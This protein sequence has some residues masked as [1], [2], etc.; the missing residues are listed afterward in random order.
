M[1]GLTLCRWELPLRARWGEQERDWH[2]ILLEH[3]P[4]AHPDSVM[5]STELVADVLAPEASDAVVT[6]LWRRIP[7]CLRETLKE[8]QEASVRFALRR[9]DHILLADE[10]NGP[11]IELGTVCRPHARWLAQS[12]PASP[13]PCRAVG[14]GKSLQ[15]RAPANQ[16]RIAA[17][18]MPHHP[19][20]S[21]THSRI[22]ARGLCMLLAP[23]AVRWWWQALAIAAAYSKPSAADEYFWPV[24][25]VC[26]TSMRDVWLS[27]VERW[28]PAVPPEEICVLRSSMDMVTQRAITVCSYKMMQRLREP[29][30]LRH[31]RDPFRCVIL[32]ES[33]NAQYYDPDDAR[34]FWQRNAAGGKGGGGKGGQGGSGGRGRGRGGGSSGSGKAGVRGG[35]GGEHVGRSTATSS[36]EDEK[37]RYTT[38]RVL[39]TVPEGH[40][41]R[42]KLLLLSGT[43]MKSGFAAFF[44]QLHLL[45]PR[46]FPRY[47]EYRAR[48]CHEGDSRKSRDDGAAS[49]VS[50]TLALCMVRRLKADVLTRAD[51]LPPKM[52]QVVRVQIDSK[53]CRVHLAKLQARYSEALAAMPPKPQAIKVARLQFWQATGLAKAGTGADELV[54]RFALGRKRSRG[55]VEDGGKAIAGQAAAVCDDDDVEDA[56]SAADAEEMVGS[57]DGVSLG[58]WLREAAVMMTEP[59]QGKMLIFAHHIAVMDALA[60]L[61]DEVRSKA[62]RDGPAGGFDFIRVDGSTTDRTDQLRRFETDPSV[63]VALLSLTA[64]STGVTLNA[65]N[66]VVFAEL[67]G[68]WAELAQAED[69]CHRIGQT[70]PV[71]S[72][73]L[74][75]DA[76]FDEVL[77]PRLLKQKERTAEVLHDRIGASQEMNEA[78]EAQPA[79]SRPM[80]GSTSGETLAAQASA[81]PA[82]SSDDDPASAPKPRAKTLITP[83]SPDSDDEGLADVN[84]VG[85]RLTDDDDDHASIAGGV[86]DATDATADGTDD[87]V[88]LDAIFSEQPDASTPSARPEECALVEAAA[89]AEAA[90]IGRAGFWPSPWSTRFFVYGLLQ[91]GDATLDRDGSR[92]EP[93]ER[94]R[95]LERSFDASPLADADHVARQH[96]HHCSSKERRAQAAA[97]RLQWNALS[98]MQRGA[99]RELATRAW[100][101]LRL[102][103]LEELERA[104]NAVARAVGF[105]R[106]RYAAVAEFE[107]GGTNT[108]EIAWRMT[109]TLDPKTW[110]V[111]RHPSPTREA[112]DW[113][114]VYC[115]GERDASG[116]RCEPE[117]PFCSSGCADAYH[118]R[119]G[120][121]ARGRQLCFDRD[122]GVCAMCTRDCHALYLKLRP[123]T[124]TRRREVL[125]AEFAASSD[126]SGPPTRWRGLLLTKERFEGIVKRCQAGDLWQ[127]DHVQAVAEGGGQAVS[128][129]QYQTLCVPCHLAKTAQEK[130]ARAAKRR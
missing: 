21:H 107:A 10:S 47:A 69:R 112:S 79:E 87:P 81:L 9:D 26:P 90:G 73:F 100:R 61:L 8:Y 13:P 46:S 85:R 102:P 24:L 67:Y 123:L 128:E 15:V 101:P 36:E 56:A 33:H 97:F 38:L 129:T 37:Q 104:H 94:H 92:A 34:H 44:G 108:R 70:R 88:A 19:P 35:G 3:F 110:V 27:L 50:G 105:T 54:A 4:D 5:T 82:P 31:L 14:L 113:L 68:N 59:P 109:K 6:R 16:R 17:R 42:Q 76:S 95:Y 60:R 29:L 52:R 77:W 121:G 66:T 23:C 74:V 7:W 122:H 51:A 48:Y 43:P 72:Y 125:C 118:L 103:L 71:S 64:F 96:L 84:A 22:H 62:R 93:P 32:D 2:P 53:R 39:C 126:G 83:L 99:L 80:G 1:F 57:D 119:V 120:H 40:R 25:I 117:A 41:G 28:L 45:K 116:K 115:S 30:K 91:G 130:Q 49:E 75:A 111:T 127:A 78:S 98:T 55:A 11:T 86:G 12:V 106:Q 20:Q 65:A 58:D 89:E 63:R 114:C 18:A 124:A